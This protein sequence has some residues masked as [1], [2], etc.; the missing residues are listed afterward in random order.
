MNDRCLCVAQAVFTAIVLCAS[1][2]IVRAADRP[3]TEDCIEASDASIQASIA[4]KLRAARAHFLVCAASSCPADI[5]KECVRRVDETN[6]AIP[7]IIF[8][9]KDGSGADISAVR[10]TMDGELITDRLEGTAVPID[11][12]SHTFVFE[13]AGMPPITKRFVIRESQKDRPEVVVFVPASTV[14]PSV[15]TSKPAGSLPSTPDRNASS[16][17]PG[18]GTQKILAIVAAS[19]GVVG[20]GVGG[21]A[22]ALA[23][24]KKSDAEKV[25]PSNPCG[26][27]E[28]DGVN[29]WKDAASTGNISTVGFIVGA[30]GLVGGVVLWFTAPGASVEPS[31]QVGFGPGSLQVRA[32]W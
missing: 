25:C 15:P 17:S 28:G 31:T 11:P 1:A 3:T 22:G 10:V 16:E 14:V 2:G 5:R 32:T 21:V 7:T 23:L 29:K 13:T 18:L 6:A 9:A 19:I 26:A 20:L 27:T 24:S 12:G 4:H 30:A 8:E